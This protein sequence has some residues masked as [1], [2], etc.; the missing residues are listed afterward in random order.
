M[1]TPQRSRVPRGLQCTASRS[2]AGVGRRCSNG[3]G[4]KLSTR[5]SNDHRGSASA[6]LSWT[7]REAQPE[8]V[9]ARRP[10]G[11]HSTLAATPLQPPSANITL[12]RVSRS[13]TFPG[14]A[15][16]PATTPK[17]EPCHLSYAVLSLVA[18]VWFD[19]LTFTCH[20]APPQLIV[21]H[22]FPSLEAVAPACSRPHVAAAR[23]DTSAS[24][25]RRAPLRRHSLGAPVGRPLPRRLGR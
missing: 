6:A 18:F 2:P 15:D 10:S 19:E 17:P 24:P 21:E 3:K 1:R 20:A 22:P 9:S 14:V 4:C 8:F 25:A 11:P 12:T 13:A 16:G 23:S 7:K 5:A